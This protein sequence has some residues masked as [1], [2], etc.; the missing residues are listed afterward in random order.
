MYK[1]KIVGIGPGHPDYILPTA[2]KA[3]ESSDIL[4]GG[5]R[6]LDAFSSMN[7]EKF[8]YQSNLDEMLQ[9]VIDNKATNKIAIV[10]SGDTG[11]YSLLD[12]FKRHL[13]E[14]DIQAIPGISS[15]QYLFAK[16]NKSYKDYGLLSVHG[17]ELDIIKKLNDYKGLFL[18]TDKKQD[19]ATIAEKLVQ[20]GLG[21]S[22]MTIGENLSYDDEKIET[23]TAYECVNRTYST[24]CVV[25]IEK[26]EL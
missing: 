2:M 23:I 17:R 3:I 25:V 26:N 11:F 19:P 9:F 22:L 8:I 21:D 24:L 18:L 7:I 14:E 20:N 15:Y 5:K 12:Y 13:G 10:V 16:L 6:N 1:V 4:V